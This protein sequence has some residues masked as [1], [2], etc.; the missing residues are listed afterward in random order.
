MNIKEK[1]REIGKY[2]KKVKKEKM[3]FKCKKDTESG[4]C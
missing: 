2:E 3:F 4:S 1:R